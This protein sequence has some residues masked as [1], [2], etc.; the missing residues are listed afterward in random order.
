MG[1]EPWTARCRF[2]GVPLENLATETIFQ[3][4]TSLRLLFKKT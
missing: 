3:N 2:L 1:S 4:V